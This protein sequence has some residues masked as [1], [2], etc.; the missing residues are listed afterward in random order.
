[1]ESI[2]EFGETINFIDKITILIFDYFRKVIMQGR[3]SVV[4]L[5]FKSYYH[6]SSKVIGF[7]IGKNLILYVLIFLSQSTFLLSSFASVTV[8]YSFSW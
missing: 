5:L 6:Q 3:E 1:M 7:K 2:A 4:A 8:S